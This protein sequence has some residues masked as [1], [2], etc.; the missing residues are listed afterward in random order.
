MNSFIRT[1]KL[2]EEH[3]LTLFFRI[4]GTGTGARHR[5]YSSFWGYNLFYKSLGL[6]IR[7]LFRWIKYRIVRG[8]YE[9]DCSFYT[10][11]GYNPVNPGAIESVQHLV[12]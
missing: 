10:V 6:E 12:A 2:I 9:M 5:F 3:V 7:Y 1:V 8:T 11:P 4:T